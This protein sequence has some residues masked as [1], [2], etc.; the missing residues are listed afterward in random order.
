M[1]YKHVTFRIPQP[2]ALQVKEVAKFSGWQLADLQRTLI[3]IGATF[4]L[5]SYGNEA[6]EEAATTLMSGMKLLRFSRSFSL[7]PN[8]RPYAFRQR[9]GKSTVTTLG[10]PESVCDVIAAYA[11]LRHASRNQV[12]SKCLQ[13]GLLVY[14]K[15]QATVLGA[16][17]NPP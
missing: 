2:L 8:R 6:T 11:E 10:F 17:R 5:L 4:F 9:L 12:Y 13:Q 14:L 16:A 3:C 7:A 15:T 1:V